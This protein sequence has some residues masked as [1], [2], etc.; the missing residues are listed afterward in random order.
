MSETNASQFTKLTIDI[1]DY[2]S[3][4]EKKLY[5]FFASPKVI[6]EK[7][8]NSILKYIKINNININSILEPS[9]GTC[10]IVHV[11][12]KIFDNCVIDAIELNPTIYNAIQHLTFKNKVNIIQGD[13]LKKNQDD[14]KYCL[15]VVNPPYLVCKK[16]DVPKKYHEYIVGRPNVFCVFIIHSIE[17]TKESGLLAFILSKSLLNSIY[18]DKIRKYI[19]K[20]C[21]IIEIIDFQ[22]DNKFIDTDQSTV[23]IV[24]QKYSYG[25]LIH[26]MDDYTLLINET[27]LFTTSK[28]KLETILQGSTTIQKLGLTVR[29]G[30]IVW[31]EHKEK[32]TS[33]DSKT[34]LIYSTNI[35]KDNKIMLTSFKNNEKKQY[36]N[37]QGKSE[38]ILAVYRGHGNSTYKLNYALVDFQSYLCE[39]HINEIYSQKPMERETLIELLNKI[40]KGF[41]NNKT[42]EFIKLFVGNNSLSQK[43]LETIFPIYL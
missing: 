38:P 3:K 17:M 2:M 4:N 11:C 18:Y 26:E 32:L 36:I 16:T 5:G 10:E 27:Y 21:K 20:T 29:T 8:L 19:K 42:T 14:K 25:E 6:I 41:E 22:E 33:D 31:N 13:F 9:C 15:T 7:L 28:S 24:L 35:T 23:G 30:N 39:N 43:E 34:K 37:I 40:M 12:D 1:T